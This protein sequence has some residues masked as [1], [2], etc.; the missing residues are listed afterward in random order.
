MTQEEIVRQLQTG[1]QR[2]NTLMATEKDAE[3]KL[4]DAHEAR[5][6]TEGEV[7]VWEALLQASVKQG[8]QKEPVNDG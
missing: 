8:A 2:L 6:Q 7:A 1:Q 3:I 4:H 5:L